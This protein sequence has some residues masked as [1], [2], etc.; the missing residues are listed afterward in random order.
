MLDPE[1]F[2]GSLCEVRVDLDLVDR[3]HDRCLIKQSGEV[4]DHEVADADGAHLAVG[5]QGLQSP[6]CLEGLVEAMKCL[7]V[8]VVADPDL[9]LEEH[10]RPVEPRVADRLPTCRSLP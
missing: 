6:L 5:E 7:V 8:A 1:P 9:G 10:L 3:G 4:L 2:H